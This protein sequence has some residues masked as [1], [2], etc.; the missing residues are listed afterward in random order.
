MNIDD[1]VFTPK[2]VLDEN[3]CRPLSNWSTKD[4]INNYCQ[5][6]LQ[7]IVEIEDFDSFN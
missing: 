6:H 3:I 1:K 2:H 5:I 4:I 7:K